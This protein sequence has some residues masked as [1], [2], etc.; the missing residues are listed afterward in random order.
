VQGEAHRPSEEEAGLKRIVFGVVPMKLTVST[1]IELKPGE[2]VLLLSPGKDDDVA[3]SVGDLLRRHY[4]VDPIPLRFMKGNV[5]QG[6]EGCDILTDEGSIGVSERISGLAP[7]AGMVITLPSR[8][9]GKLQS[10][11]DVARLLRGLVLPIQAL[12]KSPAGKFLVLIH[13]REDAG[14]LNGLLVEGILGMLL[15]AAQEHSSVLFRTLEIGRDTDLGAALSAALD[16]GYAA[17]EMMHRDGGV[18]TS[19]GHVAP[20]AFGHISRL[21]LRPGDVLVMSGGATGIGA[22][23]ARSLVPFKPRLVFLGRTSLDQV[24]PKTSEIAR[25][26]ADLHSAVGHVGESI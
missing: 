5:E 1:P 6:E 10:M 23:L 9:P 15:S 21:D 4:G 25:T 2:S 3:G 17:V 20:S 24:T 14:T 19:E 11:A 18:F 22:H 16:R 8:G 12:L 26:L 7:L 13:A